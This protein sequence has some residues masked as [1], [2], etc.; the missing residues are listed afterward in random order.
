MNCGLLHNYPLQTI[1]LQHCTPPI[2]YLLLS[3]CSNPVNSP[4]SQVWEGCLG[5]LQ[6]RGATRKKLCV[7]ATVFWKSS[8]CPMWG[9]QS[10][11]CTGTEGCWKHQL[12]PRYLPIPQSL[13]E[14]LTVFARV[15][16]KVVYVITKLLHNYSTEIGQLQYHLTSTG[17]LQTTKAFL[18]SVMQRNLG[19]SGVQN[20]LH[21]FFELCEHDLFL[22]Y[23]YSQFAIGTWTT[24]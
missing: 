22:F 20:S 2:W 5:W 1:S 7:T 18:S 10:Y 14:T 21:C 17:E 11:S 16:V 23:T 9:A 4:A 15:K 13:A 12:K 3:H 19:Q 24:K 8:H 6:S